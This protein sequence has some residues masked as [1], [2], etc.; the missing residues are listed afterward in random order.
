MTNSQ[1]N[2]HATYAYSHKILYSLNQL[3]LRPSSIQ[4]M[5]DHHTTRTYLTPDNRLPT[6]WPLRRPHGEDRRGSQ[7]HPMGQA[8]L[9]TYSP[10]SESATINTD[11]TT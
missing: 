5:L 7:Q 6:A 2:R 11:M 1:L 10:T 3:P 8:E 4:S 9:P